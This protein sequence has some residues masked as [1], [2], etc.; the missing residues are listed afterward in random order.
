M[1]VRTMDSLDYRS[2]FEEA[3]SYRQPMLV[4]EVQVLP[5]VQGFTTYPI[6]PRCNRS[7]DREY[8]SYC[9]RCGQ[10]LDW[11]QLSKASRRL[12]LK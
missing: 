11:S 12:P 3:W 10:A 4:V 7:I 5:Y 2:S 9:D 6:C 8:M 1:E